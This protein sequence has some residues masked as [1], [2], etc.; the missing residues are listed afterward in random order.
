M[1]RG[2]RVGGHPLHAA[3][4]DFPLVLFLLWVALD[5]VALGGGGALFWTL[6]HWALI[7]GV[8]AAGLAAYG[9]YMLAAAWYGR[10]VTR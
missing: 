3:L 2:L 10:I 8:V 6:G 5:A 9:V 7:A 1:S 4:S